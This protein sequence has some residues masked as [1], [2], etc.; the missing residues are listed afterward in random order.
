MSQWNLV[1]SGKLY[2]H[3]TNAVNSV[4]DYFLLLMGKTFTRLF[5]NIYLTTR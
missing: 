1:F 5:N 3:Q 4:I 2:L